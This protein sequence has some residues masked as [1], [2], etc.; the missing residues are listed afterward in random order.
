MDTSHSA[1]RLSTI[2]S[3]RKH[4][5]T[6]RENQCSRKLCSY[7]SSSNVGLEFNAR[8]SILYNEMYIKI[9]L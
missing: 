3:V 9:Y 8:G 7:M 5:V 1:K 4:Y 6:C 2:P